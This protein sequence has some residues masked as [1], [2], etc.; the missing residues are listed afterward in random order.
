MGSRAGPMGH[1]ASRLGLGV[2]HRPFCPRDSQFKHAETLAGHPASRL[3][4]GHARSPCRPL[5]AETPE[6]HPASR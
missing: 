3:G 6:G 5:G 2:T 1:P 4:L